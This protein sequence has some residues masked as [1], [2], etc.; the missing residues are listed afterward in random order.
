MRTTT[1]CTSAGAAEG[2]GE[3]ER[4]FMGRTRRHPRAALRPARG[5]IWTRSGC[6]R[7]TR[8][9]ERRAERA[10]CSTARGTRRRRDTRFTMS[11]KRDEY[12]NQTTRQLSMDSRSRPDL[13]VWAQLHRRRLVPCATRARRAPEAHV[14]ADRARRDAHNHFASTG[15]GAPPHAAPKP[16]PLSSRHAA[17]QRV[18]VVVVHVPPPCRDA[19]PATPL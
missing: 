19:D 7:R 18:V 5:S 9:R 11:T 16:D 3:R 10:R 17:E 13:A 2:E 8:W 15:C 14:P 4:A 6:A 1:R 12:D